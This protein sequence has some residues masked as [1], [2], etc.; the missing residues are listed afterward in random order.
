M[1]SFHHT[2]TY[3]FIAFIIPSVNSPVFHIDHEE[4]AVFHLTSEYIHKLNKY[5]LLLELE[6][7]RHFTF[8]LTKFHENIQK[9]SNRI[10]KYLK[11][12]KAKNIHN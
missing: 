1:H 4:A 9:V 5:E 10:N 11:E 7:V 8:F 6:C 2:P 3:T 12:V